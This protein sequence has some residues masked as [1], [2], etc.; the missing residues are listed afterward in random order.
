MNPSGDVRL[1][2]VSQ[3]C[4]TNQPLFSRLIGVIMEAKERVE[5]NGRVASEGGILG[6]KEIAAT[7]AFV[8]GQA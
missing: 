8:S 3:N 5:G 7:S 6:C 2:V 4:E 1:I